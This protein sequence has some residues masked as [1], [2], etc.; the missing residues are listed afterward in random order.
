[1]VPLMGRQDDQSHLCAGQHH[2]AELLE[3]MLRH[4]GNWVMIGDS[5]HGAVIND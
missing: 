3:T 5:P 4:V 2:G 1:M